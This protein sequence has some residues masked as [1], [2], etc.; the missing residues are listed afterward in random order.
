MAGANN[1]KPLRNRPTGLPLFF[2]AAS[3]AKPRKNQLLSAS[4][5]RTPQRSMITA[6][7]RHRKNSRQHKTNSL[8]A[9]SCSPTQ[10]NTLVRPGTPEWLDHALSAKT[11]PFQAY[12]NSNPGIIH[13]IT[14]KL[15]LT[16]RGTPR[17]SLTT[18]FTDLA[19][20]A[21]VA[22]ITTDRPKDQTSAVV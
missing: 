13:G 2:P 9:E 17:K 20:T 18:Q 7:G 1:R 19:I 22:E 4:S 11:Q 12:P 8:A 6:Q 14:N 5:T 16:N 15:Q 3:L 10:A 21:A